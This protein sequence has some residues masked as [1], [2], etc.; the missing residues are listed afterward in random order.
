MAKEQKP[1]YKAGDG[2]VLSIVSENLNKHGKIKAKNKKREK[3]LK[4]ACMH[5]AVTKRGNV[6]MRI[7]TSDNRSTCR[8]CGATFKAGTYEH[9]EVRKMVKGATELVNNLKFLT[10]AI[11]GGSQAVRYSSELGSMLYLL[12][13]NYD[14]VAKI[15]KKADSVR[16]KK[17]RKKDNSES[18]SLGSWR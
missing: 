10:I 15:A 17:K 12:P 3:V 2:S 6:K 1:S 5:H 13:G 4:G 9:D 11:G 14:K 18:A 8:M 16:K 7:K